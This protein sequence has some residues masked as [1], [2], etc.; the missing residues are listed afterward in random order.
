MACRRLV[1]KCVTQPFYR[2]WDI[3][4][5]IPRRLA[6]AALVLLVSLVPGR[7]VT[8]LPQEQAI[9]G[10]M[11]DNSQQARRGMVLD[12]IVQAVAEAQA[13]DMA[14]N[15]YFSD[16]NPQGVG[17]NYLLRQAGY[18]L[19]ASWGTGATLNYTE[20]IAAGASD[21]SDT[22]S[23]WMNSPPHKEHLLA[24]NSFF[25]SETHYGV[26]YAYNPGS[27]YQWYWVVITAPPEPVEIISP[28]PVTKLKE[29]S[30][31]VL[32][33]A[34]PSTGAV[35]VQLRVENSGG[36]G[37]YQP[38]TGLAKWTGTVSGLA[39]G[40]NVIRVQTL[41]ASGNVVAEAKTEVDYVVQ[42]TL[43]VSVSG[44]GSVTG[45]LLGSHQEPEGQPVGIR[46]LPAAGSIFTGW[47]GDIVSGS[48][49]I[50]FTMPATETLVANFEANPYIPISGP[51]LGLLTTGAG[52]PAGMVEL[53]VTTGGL[54]TGRVMLNGKWY[55]V[56]GALN[57]SGAATVAIRGT[58]WTVSLQADL[59][60]GSGLIAG[61]VSNGT[62]SDQFSINQSTYNPKTRIAP[63]AGQY[64]MALSPAGPGNAATVPQ[65][66]GFATM[67]IYGAGGASITGKM[68]DG[69]AFCTTGSVTNDG[70][71]SLYFV[72][73]GAPAGT[74]VNGVLNFAPT[75]SSDAEGTLWWTK[76]A[77]ARDPY[78][79]QG[80]STQVQAT[81]SR[82]VRPVAGVDAMA[83]SPGVTAAEFVGGILGQQ[84]VSAEVMVTQAGKVTM[85]TPG[86]PNVALGIN[87][88]SG[89]VS[90]TFEPVPGKGPQ[91]VRGVVLQK[92]N[93]AF[94]YFWMA[95]ESGEFSLTPGQ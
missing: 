7:A 50:T 90:G 61:S 49:T 2:L 85:V 9:A 17:P 27:T 47:T 68:A 76:G 52:A 72:P 69:T 8:L 88:A 51:Y 38:G 34:D 83:V 89:L 67:T 70:T 40:P 94:G 80:F 5:F 32:G 14:N 11:V 93:D 79:P 44:S 59:T 71:L 78:Y 81:A 48:P 1:S 30:A 57:L 63:E 20:S 66:S 74:Y 21:P 33:L 25:A 23:A 43:N 42:G 82:Y 24:Q 84:D 18:V 53:T 62:V 31:T 60:G 55:G 37:V 36:V 91:A 39:P 16:T 56:A 92:Q 73:S 65:G 46:A 58:A 54:F 6:L 64:T 45:G 22:W 19:P 26:G 28:L 10:D 77:N 41:G 87:V 3:H 13:A 15:N 86:A 4:F 12:P 35:S 95:G 75:D 29:P